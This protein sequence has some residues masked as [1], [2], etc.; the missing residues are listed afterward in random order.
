MGNLFGDTLLKRSIPRCE[1]GCLG[2]NPIMQFLDAKHR[3]Y[4]RDQRCVVVSVTTS[5][6]SI[7]RLLSVNDL[8]ESGSGGVR[9]PA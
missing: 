6:T 1:F 5:G 4:A 8:V 2:L 3:A 9:N 7:V